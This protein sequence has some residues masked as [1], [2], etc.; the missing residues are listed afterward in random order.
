MLFHVARNRSTIALTKDS[1]VRGDLPRADRGGLCRA[2]LDVEVGTV[3]AANLVG[4]TLAVLI[5]VLLGAAL[6][7][8]ERF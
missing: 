1:Y 7:F 3:S 5:A 6:V 4:L 8:P 2:R